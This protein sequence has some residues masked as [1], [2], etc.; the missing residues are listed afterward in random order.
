MQRMWNE[1]GM[2]AYTEKG[3]HTGGP[4]VALG[5]KGSVLAGPKLHGEEG[6]G[7][8]P[9]CLLQSFHAPHGLT[10]HMPTCKLDV[11]SIGCLDRV[12]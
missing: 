7:T 6:D 12:L 11:L 3:L 2:I 4:G 5:G 10:C 1:G 9:A 8:I